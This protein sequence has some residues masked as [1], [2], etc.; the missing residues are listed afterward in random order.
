MFWTVGFPKTSI[1]SSS[2]KR[3]VR[4]STRTWRV[5]RILGCHGC[6]MP[7]FITPRIQF[8]GIF[9]Y[10]FSWLLWFSCLGRYT[11]PMDPKKVRSDDPICW[12]LGETCRDIQVTTATR[13]SLYRVHCMKP[14]HWFWMIMDD[15]LMVLDLHGL[16][17]Q[18]C[19][20]RPTTHCIEFNQL[21]PTI[22]PWKLEEKT[23][24]HN[25]PR[26]QQNCKG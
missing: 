26:N 18:N 3:R 25:A 9:T 7:W 15:L 8:V 23:L 10:R 17:T 14:L 13:Y 24:P 6:R 22:K 20:N 16:L 4:S 12:Q 5:R 11:S 19:S 1:M 21:R 2:C